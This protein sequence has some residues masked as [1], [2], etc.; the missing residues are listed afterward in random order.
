LDG[1]Q[2]VLF[3]AEGIKRGP[4]S[5]RTREF[6]QQVGFAFLIVLMGFAFWN[7]ISRNWS[8]FVGWSSGLIDWFSQRG[9]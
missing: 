4:L 5:L 8:S 7:D 6:V 1:G 3:I 2:A 9:L